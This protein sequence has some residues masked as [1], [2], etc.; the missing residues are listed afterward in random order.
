MINAT[1]R[2]LLRCF[3]TLWTTPPP[4]P[5]LSSDHA[6]RLLSPLPPLQQCQT[7]LGCLPPYTFSTNASSRTPH[8]NRRWART[9]TPDHRARTHQRLTTHRAPLGMDI[10]KARTHRLPRG[11]LT[12]HLRHL[13]PLASHACSRVGFAAVIQTVT[14]DHLGPERYHV[15]KYPAHKC[16][17]R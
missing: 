12:H 1:W 15:L 13:T 10:A 5:T 17:N 6:P 16:L 8:R 14:P 2:L 3:R 9:D 7:H 11:D 4:P